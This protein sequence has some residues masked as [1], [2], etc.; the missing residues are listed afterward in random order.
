[1]QVSTTAKA[2]APG[3]LLSAD[4][5]GGSIL[6]VQAPGGNGAAL[7]DMTLT[8]Q[9]TPYDRIFPPSEPPISTPGGTLV[10]PR[11]FALNNARLA[12]QDVLLIH[13]A[14]L[15]QW[16]F[17]GCGGCT[18]TLS[19][20]TLHGPHRHFSALFGLAVADQHL[21]LGHLHL[22]VLSAAGKV[23][24]TAKGFTRAGHG[25]QLLSISLDGGAKLQIAWDDVP[26]TVFAL[27]VA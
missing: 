3:A 20:A 22:A 16:S 5:D 25:P 19:L 26:L 2:G 27:T 24:R 1:M 11:L 4:I 17:I 9:A 12:D 15:E 10:D 14:A 13:Q 21:G 7:Y 23:V 8:G 18:A 6:A